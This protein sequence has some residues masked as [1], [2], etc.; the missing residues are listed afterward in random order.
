MRRNTDN[1]ITA[2][3]CSITVVE[4]NNPDI[5]VVQFPVITYP[6]PVTPPKKKTPPPPPAVPKLTAEELALKK[7][8]ESWDWAG[9]GIS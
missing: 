3:E 7:A 8:T 9:F 2:A 6:V 5:T 1:E 4:V